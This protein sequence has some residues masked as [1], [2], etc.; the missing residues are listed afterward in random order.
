MYSDLANGVAC[1]WLIKPKPI[2]KANLPTNAYVY[3]SL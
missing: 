3:C 1:D 2:Y